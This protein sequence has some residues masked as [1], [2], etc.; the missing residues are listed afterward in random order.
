M[1]PSLGKGLQS[2]SV[3]LFSTF[4]SIY[5][6][7]IIS[8]AIFRNL[9]NFQRRPSSLLWCC[10][11]CHPSA[12]SKI[13]ATQWNP[14]HLG[15]TPIEQSQRL[16]RLTFY[17]HPQWSSGSPRSLQPCLPARWGTAQSSPAF[18]A[19]ACE[20]LTKVYKF[21]SCVCPVC[22]LGHDTQNRNRVLRFFTLLCIPNT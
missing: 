8:P 12:F 21:Q 20:Y 5:Q 17:T 4:L 19:L 22:I 7:V 16:H 15:L 14:S 9:P 1:P 18:Q 6:S 3:S 10:F 2:P 13:P 11:D